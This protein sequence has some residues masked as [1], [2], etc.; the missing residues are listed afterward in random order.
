MPENKHSPVLSAACSL[1][2]IGIHAVT[3]WQCCAMAGK[4][5]ICQ[6]VFPQEK[7][8]KKSNGC[9]CSAGIRRIFSALF[10]GNCIIISKC[11]VRECSPRP[12]FNTLQLC[13]THLDE[14][15]LC[16][17]ECVNKCSPF[18]IRYTAIILIIVSCNLIYV[19]LSV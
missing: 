1:C 17:C 8:K 9:L 19:C 16:V 4:G 5:I 10:C 2:L 14:V 12:Q 13:T 11:H 18:T 3:F 15:P 7:K 6:C